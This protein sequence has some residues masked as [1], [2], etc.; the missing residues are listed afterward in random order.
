MDIEG[1]TD[2]STIRDSD[3]S[4]EGGP[5]GWLAFA[6]VAGLFLLAVVITVFVSVF[7]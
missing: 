5:P 6:V 1:K 3:P 4:T 7:T 2:Q